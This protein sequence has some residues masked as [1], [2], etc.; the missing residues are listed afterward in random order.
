MVVLSQ[1]DD[2]GPGV[3]VEEGGVGWA[4][5]DVWGDG[6]GGLMG[7]VAVRGGGEACRFA[8]LGGEIG[9]P[10]RGTRGAGA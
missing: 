2:A 5:G 1:G 3:Q 6:A 9:M 7:V 10:G 8:G 4:G